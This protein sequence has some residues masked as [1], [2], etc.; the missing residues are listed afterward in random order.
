LNKIKLS[1]KLDKE[2][3]LNNSKILARKLLGKTLVLRTKG[4]VL[5]GKIVETEAYLGVRDAASHSYRGRVTP[6]N[7]IMFEDG[8]LVYIYLIYGMYFCF[9]IVSN[10]RG[11]PEAVFIRALEPLSG[12]SLMRKNNMGVKSGKMLTNGP[13]RWTR[14]FGIDK[15]FLGEKIYGRRIY[16]TANKDI[17]PAEIIKT[18]RIGVDFAKE[19]KDWPLRFYVKDN[20]FVSYK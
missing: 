3:Y 12:V 13:C 6:R 19:A 4:Q 5:A 7:K 16:I 10:K 18:K 15:S 11:I 9:N 8:G 20:P 14:S 2:F 17:S 1:P